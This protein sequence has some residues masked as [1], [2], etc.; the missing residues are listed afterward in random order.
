M[1]K[2]LQPDEFE[3]IIQPLPARD[4]TLLREQEITP[5]WLRENIGRCRK[6]MKRDL[7]IGPVWVILYGILL[8]KTG[9][10]NLTIGIF[11]IGAV[12]FIYTIFTTGSF[13]LNRK[14]VGVYEAL[15]KKMEE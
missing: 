5:E 6:L 7:W 1:P 14:R 13:G 2:K 10:S 11:V 15:L 4:R 9:Y 8:F 12:Y 3:Q